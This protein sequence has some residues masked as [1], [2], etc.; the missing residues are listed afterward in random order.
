[1]LCENLIGIDESLR[2]EDPDKVRLWLLFK[3][4]SPPS[5]APASL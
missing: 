1:M 2:V 5:G 4:G 3:K